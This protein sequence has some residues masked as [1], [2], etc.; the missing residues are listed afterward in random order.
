VIARPHPL[1]SDAAR[2]RAT[3]WRNKNLEFAGATLDEAAGELQRYFDVDIRFEASL[4][5]LRVGGNML[6]T[7][8]DPLDGFVKALTFMHHDIR[9]TV[10]GSPSGHRIVTIRKKVNRHTDDDGSAEAPPN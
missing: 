2:K 6:L 8:K 1:E 3:T 10:Q 5:S 7:R 9:V 4:K